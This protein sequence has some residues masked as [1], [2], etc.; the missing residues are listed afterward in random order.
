MIFAPCKFEQNK[1]LFRKQEKYPATFKTEFVGSES[2]VL[3]K[4]SAKNGP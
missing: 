3:D 1:F 2:D 4:D